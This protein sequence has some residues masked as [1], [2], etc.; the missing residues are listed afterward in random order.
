DI[1]SAFGQTE[2]SG[3]TTMLKGADS[4]RKLGS[5]GKPVIGVE[6]RIVDDEGRDVAPGEVGELLYRGP[7][8]MAGYHGRPDAPDE[9]FA[10]G[11]VTFV[12]WR[13]A[14]KPTWPDCRRSSSTRSRPI[15]SRSGSDAATGTNLSCSA[16]TLRT[17]QE[18]A[19]SRICR[20]PSVTSPLASAFSREKSS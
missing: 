4:L 13:P 1:V 5:V 7:M 10:R 20:P 6:I 11:R 9:A 3:T 12:A 16:I 2:M 15:R 8:V 17:G 19:S 18:I 14:A